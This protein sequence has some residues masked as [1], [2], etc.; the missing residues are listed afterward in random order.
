MNAKKRQTIVYIC[1]GLVMIWALSNI[2]GKS[3]KKQKPTEQPLSTVKQITAVEKS[4]EAIDIAKYD[5]LSWGRD[6]FYRF[7]AKKTGQVDQP[8][9]VVGWELGGIL[10]SENNPSAVINKK[11]VRHGDIVNGARVVKISK[12]IVI[13]EKDN[14]EFTLNI[15]KDKS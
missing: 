1:A 9:A 5:K 10:W 13:L 8:E 15:K 4:V 2:M 3:S 6:P 11:I 12:D 14:T 7:T